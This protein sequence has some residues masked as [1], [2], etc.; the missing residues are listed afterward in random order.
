ME[1]EKEQHQHS[2]QWILVHRVISSV[3][4]HAT[5]KYWL[6]FLMHAISWNFNFTL[7]ENVYRKLQFR[8]MFNALIDSP[9]RRMGSDAAAIILVFDLMVCCETDGKASKNA[10]IIEGQHVPNRLFVVEVTSQ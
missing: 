10:N 8:Q 1:D 9:N 4:R 6:Q 7:R 3:Q 5:R 2:E